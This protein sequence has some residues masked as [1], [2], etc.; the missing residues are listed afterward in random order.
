M[1]DLTQRWTVGVARIRRL[2]MEMLRRSDEFREPIAE[3]VELLD[4]LDEGLRPLLG[5]QQTPGPAAHR[6]SRNRPKRYRIEERRR[7]S[8]LV[9]Y[10]EGGRQ[11]FCCPRQVYEAVAVA[12]GSLGRPAQFEELLAMAGK[13]WKATPADYLLRVCLRFWRSVT[14]PLVHKD[15]THYRAIGAGKFENAARRA[16]RNL[17]KHSD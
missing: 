17:A 6:M 2:L 1:I 5:S 13:R 14:P 7:G 3:I 16:W 4:E 11:P 15:R 9:E 12:L 8:F 10:R